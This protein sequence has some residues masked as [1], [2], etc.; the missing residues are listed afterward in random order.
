[1][2]AHLSVEASQ[3]YTHLLPAWP[4]ASACRL[5]RRQSQLAKSKQPQKY[6]TLRPFCVFSFLHNVEKIYF[7]HAVVVFWDYIQIAR[8][9][10]ASHTC[11]HFQPGGRHAPLGP[12]EARGENA[13]WRWPTR[14]PDKDGERAEMRDLKG[15]RRGE[16]WLSLIFLSLLV[17][18]SAHSDWNFIITAAQ[19]RR[20]TLNLTP[21]LARSTSCSFFPSL[22]QLF[23]LPLPIFLSPPIS[24]FTLCPFLLYSL[25]FGDSVCISQSPP[26]S[27][28]FFFLVGLLVS[29]E[30]PQLSDKADWLLIKYWITLKTF[31]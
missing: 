19:R 24:F 7:P 12:R 5:Q 8:S 16:C 30:T 27:V 20:E 25:Y 10:S 13:E 22:P 21:R 11:W 23:F 15:D 29:W 3:T 14:R 28:L 26:F 1:M 18:H 9:A 17:L 31:W 4:H 2:Q 6:K